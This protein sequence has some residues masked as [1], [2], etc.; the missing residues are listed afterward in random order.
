MGSLRKES[1]TR[2]GFLGSLVLGETQLTASLFLP[3]VILFPVT[4]RRS[5]GAYMLSRF[6]GVGAA[7]VRRRNPERSEGTRD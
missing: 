7:G 5:K 6:A 1:R 4:K 3:G 2:N